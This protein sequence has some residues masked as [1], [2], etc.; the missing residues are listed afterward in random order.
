M[1]DP[2]KHPMLWHHQIWKSLT[3]LRIYV[4]P[5]QSFRIFPFNS[6]VV[7]PCI[8]LINVKVCHLFTQ[9]QSLF[10][11]QTHYQHFRL[12]KHSLGAQLFLAF[13]IKDFYLAIPI[14]F[15]KWSTNTNAMMISTT[16]IADNYVSQGHADEE[17]VSQ[18]LSV[19]SPSIT[20][21]DRPVLASFVLQELSISIRLPGFGAEDT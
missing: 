14:F 10:T 1:N 7:I 16:K 6:D 11:V 2:R 18:Y 3:T 9:A 15:D 8:C 17:G 13:S 21:T 19:F 20:R 5:L 4:K 12:A